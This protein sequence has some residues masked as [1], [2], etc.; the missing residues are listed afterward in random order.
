MSEI[1]QFREV[2]MKGWLRLGTRAIGTEIMNS[3]GRSQTQFI[4]QSCDTKIAVM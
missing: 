3:R 2:K 4:M 1:L